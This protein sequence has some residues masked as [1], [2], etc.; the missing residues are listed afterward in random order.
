[1]SEKLSKG[2]VEQVSWHE[3]GTAGK[4]KYKYPAPVITLEN[5]DSFFGSQKISIS[6]IARMTRTDIN[7]MIRPAV[8]SGKLA[9]SEKAI[10]DY[11][12]FE[13]LESG[14]FVFK[15]LRTGEKRQGKPLNK[16]F[17]VMQNPAKYTAEEREWA[18]D[19]IVAEANARL[20]G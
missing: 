10:A 9:P 4:P 2:Q 13:K 18:K 19:T 8:N 1:M 20:E 3:G 12:G 16:A 15:N 14:L 11:L 17:K 7:N 5:R 6:Q